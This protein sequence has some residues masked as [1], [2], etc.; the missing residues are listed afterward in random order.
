MMGGKNEDEGFLGFSNQTMLGELHR[1][2]ILII[3]YKGAEKMWS[4][5][6]C[7]MMK[8]YDPRANN[9]MGAGLLR[10]IMPALWIK[11]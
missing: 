1:E 11:D 8:G 7:R 3:Q 9:D 10:V 6:C 2:F 5:N 4:K